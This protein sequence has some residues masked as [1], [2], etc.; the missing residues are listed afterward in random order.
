MVYIQGFLAVFETSALFRNCCWRDGRTYKW[1]FSLWQRIWSRKLWSSE[2]TLPFELPTI[3][4]LQVSAYF[5]YIILQKM[6]V[7]YRINLLDFLKRFNKLRMIT[8]TSK[9]KTFYINQIHNP[10]IQ[11]NIQ[12]IYL[13]RIL[14][15]IHNF[16]KIEDIVPI[17]PAEI[18][19]FFL[20]NVMILQEIMYKIHYSIETSLSHRIHVSKYIWVHTVSL[21]RAMFT[22]LKLLFYTTRQVFNPGSQY[23]CMMPCRSW[24]W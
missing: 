23:G 1:C 7:N 14:I 22:S 10:T 20:W 5:L 12:G 13:H 15:F 19:F 4:K 9:M 6:H 18:F 16:F 17:F 2:W 11:P 24:N 21:N 3:I 8:I